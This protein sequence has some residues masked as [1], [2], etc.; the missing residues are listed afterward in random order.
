MTL[1]LKRLQLGYYDVIHDGEIV[2]RIYRMIGDEEHWRWMT[3]GPREHGRAERRYL[4]QPRR[5]EGGV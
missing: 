1:A 5:G 3:A 2:G 4:R